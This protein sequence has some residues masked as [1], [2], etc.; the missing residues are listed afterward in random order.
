MEPLNDYCQ[1]RLLIVGPARELKQF[2]RKA[3]WKEIPGAT[4][5]SLAEHSGMRIVWEFVTKAPALNS[6]RIMS[7][8]WPCLTF[9]LTC[10]CEDCRHI[11]LVRAKNG[12]L[13]QHRFKY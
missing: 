9:F 11:G 4:D 13:H 7:R 2:H 1:H 8:R 5:T 10:D 3:D 6:L 12:R